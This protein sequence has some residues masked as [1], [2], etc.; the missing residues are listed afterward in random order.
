MRN[1]IVVSRTQLTKLQRHGHLK[2]TGK[3]RLFLRTLCM[4]KKEIPALHYPRKAKPD[5]RHGIPRRHSSLNAPHMVCTHNSTA[6]YPMLSIASTTSNMSQPESGSSIAPIPSFD[7]LK[8]QIHDSSATASSHPLVLGEK[9]YHF[10]QPHLSTRDVQDERTPERQPH[11]KFVARR[12]PRSRLRWWTEFAV[13][14]A[15]GLGTAALLK[16]K[17]DIP[18]TKCV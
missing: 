10:T 12:Q 3:E 1:T 16:W 13:S 15:L 18:K 14:C 9:K 7:P 2:H 6:R 17:W 11:E 8:P 5:K 4:H